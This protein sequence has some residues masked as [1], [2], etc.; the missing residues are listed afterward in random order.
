MQKTVPYSMAIESRYPEQIAV[1]IA[2]DAGGKYNPMT[3]GWFMPVSMKP[4]MV[5]IAVG[6][7]RHTLSAI[8][9]A[10]SFVLSLLSEPQSDL[11]RYFGTHSGRDTDKLASIRCDTVPAEKIDG[12]LI[13]DAV[14]NFECSVKDEVVSGDHVVFI[15]EVVCSHVTN[16]PVNRLFTLVKA[17]HLDGVR[18]KTVEG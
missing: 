12:R 18:Q 7:S 4:P 13:R 1:C 15:A 17:E 8:R 10:K 5:A 6:Q 2:K 16:N 11:A 9:H 14:A 3:I